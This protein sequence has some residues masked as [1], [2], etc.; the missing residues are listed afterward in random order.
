MEEL[1]LAM[2]WGC[3]AVIVYGIYK[4]IKVRREHKR[5][6]KIRLAELQAKIEAD[7]KA[8]YEKKREQIQSSP[9]PPRGKETTKV[10]SPTSVPSP[11]QSVQSYSTKSDT[12]TMTTDDGFVNGM[13]TQMMIDTTI[14]SI[15][16]GT[17]SDTGKTYDR[18]VERSAG[19]SSSTREVG[20]TSSDEPSRSS[21]WSSSSSSSDSWSSSSSD[22]SPSSDW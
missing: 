11:T 22:S 18:E 19:V 12:R 3:Y 16:S 8:F 6:A 7:R 10:Y 9:V 17:D 4:F 13:L 20:Y 1:L 5:L 14:N 15:R 2:I 21:S